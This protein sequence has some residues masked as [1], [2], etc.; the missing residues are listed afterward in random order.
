MGE[1]ARDWT[2]DLEWA[3]ARYQ[4][5]PSESRREAVVL[6]CQDHVERAARRYKGIDSV[7]DLK[8]VGRMGVLK[9]LEKFDP[10]AGVKFSTYANHLITGEIKH[11]LRDRTGII[12]HPAW[13]QELRQKAGKMELVLQSRLGRPPTT[14]EIAIEIGESVAAVEDAIASRDTMSV[15]SIDS[16]EEDGA[17]HELERDDFAAIDP[18][19]LEVDDR[20]VILKAIGQ[21]RDL[22]QE[23]VRLYHFESRAQV[24]IAEE[25]GISCNYV[26]HILR[27]SMSKLR[28]I[29]AQEQHEERLTRALGGRKSAL[30]AQTGLYSEKYLHARVSEELQRLSPDE[31]CLAVIIIRFPGLEALAAQLGDAFAREFVADAGGVVK[32]QVRTLDIVCRIGEFGFGLILPATGPSASVVHDRIEVRLLEWLP[33]RLGPSTSVQALVGS[34]FAE[35]GRRTTRT[36]LAAADPRDHAQAA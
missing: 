8:Q 32:D 9:A 29:L 35:K 19:Q 7:E 24:E 3:V 28:S 30:E 15:G 26:S 22:E 5:A 27:Q 31:D 18:Q 11:Y 14:E 23:V 12:R 6:A 34:A 10:N 21:L 36:L 33:Q 25:L 13:L 16:G 4:A 20:M 1:A 2:D 17:E